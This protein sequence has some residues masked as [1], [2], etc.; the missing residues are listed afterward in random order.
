MKKRRWFAIAASPLVSGILCYCLVWAFSLMNQ[1]GQTDQAEEV[2][3]AF[4]FHILLPFLVL[5]GVPFQ[6]FVSIRLLSRWLDDS[7]SFARMYSMYYWHMSCVTIFEILVLPLGQNFTQMLHE[8]V[9]ILVV[10]I[11]YFTMN[12]LLSYFIWLKPA[13]KEKPE[14]N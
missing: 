14:K 1:N 4:L 2:G 3:G 7:I 11:F 13:R 8:S 6:Y 9:F 12:F 10:N 5:M